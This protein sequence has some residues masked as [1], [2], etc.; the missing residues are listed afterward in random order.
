MTDI[1]TLIERLEGASEGNR[2]LD[3][4]IAL[5]IGLWRACLSKHRY[6]NFENEERSFH[7]P[8]SIPE[9][10]SESGKRILLIDGAPPWPGW[11]DIA[12]LPP[13][14]ASLDAALTLI[15]DGAEYEISTLYGLARVDLP[16][17][18]EPITVNR[19]DGN[20]VLA[21]VECALR[22]RSAP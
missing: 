12:D 16:L 8:E 22:A 4:L 19:K 20:V 17:N 13:Y 21:L 18:G 5:A 15:P 6:W 2:D 11:A 1:A 7:W 3:E 9:Y 10:S 14:T